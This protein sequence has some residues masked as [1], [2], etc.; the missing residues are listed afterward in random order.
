MRPKLIIPA[1]ISSASFF[2]VSALINTGSELLIRNVGLNPERTGS[3]EILIK[4]GGH[5]E[6]LDKRE[7]CGEPVGDLLVKSSELKGIEIKGDLIPRAIDEL[8]VIAV[9][10]CFAEGRTTIRDAGELRVKETDRIKAMTSELRKLGA[11]IIE[12]EDGMII[13]GSETLNGAECDSWGDH[14]VAMSVAV[15]ATRAIGETAIIDSQ[16]VNMFLS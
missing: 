9:A 6:V 7:E 4:M 10:S 13:E 8:P 5:I 15:A 16:C 1:D 14:R 3:I 11:D 2:I 12:L